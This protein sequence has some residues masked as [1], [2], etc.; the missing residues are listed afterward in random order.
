MVRRTLTPYYRLGQDSG[1]PET[2]YDLQILGSEDNLHVNVRSDEHTAL[3]REI[4]ASGTV[5]LKNTASTL[6]LGSP[7]SMAVVGLDAA[8]NGDC[9]IYNDCNNGTL[10]VG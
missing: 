9:G 3:V 1:F 8:P 6:P 5:L 7:R 10:A 4:A 2:N